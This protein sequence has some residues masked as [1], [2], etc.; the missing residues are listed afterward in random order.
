[1]LTWLIICLVLLSIVVGLWLSVIIE[2]VAKRIAESKKLPMA[3]KLRKTKKII[4]K[5]AK[6]DKLAK[7]IE[8]LRKLR[9][10][11]A[12]SDE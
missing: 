4:S 5:E 1:M 8:Y 9:D 10:E 6:M 3:K 2:Y 7:E 11:E 12:Q